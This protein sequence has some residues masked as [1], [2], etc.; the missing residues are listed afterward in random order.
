MRWAIRYGEVDYFGV[1]ELRDG[2]RFFA[3]PLRETGRPQCWKALAVHGDGTFSEHVDDFPDLL[4]CSYMI[5]LMND[6]GYL[7]NAVW[8][9]ATDRWAPMSSA[10]G[11]MVKQIEEFEE[12]TRR[13]Q[14]D[15]PPPPP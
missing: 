14:H 10:F 7:E 9:D 4:S 15:T 11:R 1:R 12:G 5:W 8:F 3:L 13:E 2:D 6:Q